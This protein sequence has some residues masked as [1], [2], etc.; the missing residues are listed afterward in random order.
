MEIAAFR[1][2][3]RILEANLRGEIHALE[4]RMSQK[5]LTYFI[6]LWVMMGS[7]ALAIVGL[8]ATRG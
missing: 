3:V 2:D 1:S 5:L 7:M 6:S 4:A 8:V